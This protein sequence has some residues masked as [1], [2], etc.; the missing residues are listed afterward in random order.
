MDIKIKTTSETLH[1]FALYLTHAINSQLTEDPFKQILLTGSLEELTKKVID[2][3]WRT[4]N[5]PSGKTTRLT[6]TELQRTTLSFVFKIHP[7]SDRLMD[8]EFQII[9]KLILT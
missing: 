6:I 2:H 8:I 1:Q 4:R 5:N 9:N 7:V 3:L